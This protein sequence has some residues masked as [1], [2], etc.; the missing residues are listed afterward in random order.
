MRRVRD[1]LLFRLLSVAETIVNTVRLYRTCSASAS[2]ESGIFVFDEM[3]NTAEK[4]TSRR[5]VKGKGA[6]SFL[7]LE[8]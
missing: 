2:F 7:Q 6:R 8:I 4:K 3:L 5:D 1:I